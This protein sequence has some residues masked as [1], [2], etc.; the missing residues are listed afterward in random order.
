MTAR[1]RDA[2][3][4]VLQVKIQRRGI[5]LGVIAGKL[6]DAFTLDFVSTLADFAFERMFANVPWRSGFLALSIRK[7]VREG[8]FTIKPTA[9][10]AAFVEKGTATH[11]ILP[12]NASCLVFESSGGGIVFSAYAVHPGTRANPFVQRT[13]AE[14]RSKVGRIFSE[15]WTREVENG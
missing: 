1:F 5:D 10:Y 14:V 8:G 4:M 13:A 9:I 3:V 7:E 11:L 6:R 2:R 12:L 15:I